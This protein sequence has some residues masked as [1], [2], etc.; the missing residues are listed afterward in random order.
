MPFSIPVRGLQRARAVAVDICLGP[1]LASDGLKAL[2]D[3]G[4]LRLVV[5][6]WFA[7]STLAILSLLGVLA[8]TWWV[9][10]GAAASNILS[11]VNVIRRHSGAIDRMVAAGMVIVQPCALL[12]L[13][14]GRPAQAQ[15]H[16]CF[17][18]ALATLTLLFDWVA[19]LAATVLI[20]INHTLMLAFFPA[21][22][23]RDAVSMGAIAVYVPG[24]TTMTGT[25]MYI[26][27]QL[28]R[29]VSAHESAQQR[30]SMSA[31]LTEQAKIRAEDALQRAENAMHAADT[32]RSRREAAE[33][34]ASRTRREELIQLAAAFESS[35]TT[36]ADAVADAAKSLEG[37]AG[38]LSKLAHE[39]ER[40]ASDVSTLAVS[41]SEAG[42]SVASGVAEL[43]A[44]ISE[45]G[46]RVLQQTAQSSQAR[47]RSLAG[48]E[49][50][51]VLVARSNDIGSF[52]ALID[53]IA[54]RTN[55]LALNATIEAARAGD[56]GRGFAVVA[57]EVKSLAGQ[58]S[59]ASGEI[60][61][62]LSGLN[63]GADEAADAF[64]HVADAVT[65]LTDASDA[66]QAAI[67]IQRSS[68]AAMRLS[69]D[70]ATEGVE[71]MSQ[72]ICDVVSAA[73]ASDAVAKSVATAA[74]SLLK[75]VATLQIATNGFVQRLRAA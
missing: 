75:N 8:Q 4:L 30:T 37:S 33:D 47:T 63:G 45:I 24:L 68:A 6:S 39:T 28:R 32:E 53:D 56:A 65:D 14:E 34:T 42:R 38:T 48:D 60:A 50:V 15:A 3:D 27:L 11:T 13:L 40:Q 43:S 54:S 2:R 59:N 66:I 20:F 64:K 44:A 72:R 22:L 36:V 46:D 17:L 41:A 70:A 10:A 29:L 25:L 52:T 7:T 35:V 21:W 19:I 62:L 16:L 73:A 49:A 67:A 55:L 61:S 69:A 26:A 71:D 51:R 9:I 57:H 1:E 12:V 5:L 74:T 18:V 23:S 58:T 31:T